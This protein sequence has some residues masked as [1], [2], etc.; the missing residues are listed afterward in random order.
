MI[1]TALLSGLLA[2]AA[3]TSGA[4][5]INWVDW[6]SSTSTT[7]TGTLDIGG[8][9]IDVTFTNSVA[10]SFVQTAGGTDYWIARGP[11]SP[12][13]SI[14][15]N[16]VDNRPTGTDIIALGQGGTRSLT[17][18][19]AIEGLYFALVSWNGNVGTFSHD[20]QKLSMT[21]ENIDGS[22]AGA[23]SSGYW[24]SGTGTVAGN[25]FTVSGGEPHGTLFVD[26]MLSAFSFT[27][28]SEGWHGFTVGVAG[29]AAPTVPLPASGLLLAGAAAGLA[30]LRRRKR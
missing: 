12:Y 5:V 7:A 18:S 10:N 29:V 1:K 4:A 30:A 26:D 2:V 19:K 23:D 9:I 6:T 14:G 21:G 27:S 20:V 28:R 11:N 22:P 15:P 25:V 8:E 17:F 16:G 3:T 24:G 13:E